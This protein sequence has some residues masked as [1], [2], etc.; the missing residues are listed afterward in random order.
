MI[1][2][3]RRQTSYKCWKRRSLLVLELC[4]YRGYRT[5]SGNMLEGRAQVSHHKHTPLLKSRDLKQGGY[6]CYLGCDS[7][8]YAYMQPHQIVFRN[9]NH[10][11][12]KIFR[13]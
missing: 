13:N 7:Y 4:V 11:S 2:L 5:V 12:I 6:A 1:A 10:I 3:G 8:T 9:A